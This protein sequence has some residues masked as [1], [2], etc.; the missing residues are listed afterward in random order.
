MER[1]E[2]PPIFYRS[3]QASVSV[4]GY[5]LFMIICPIPENPET[6]YIARA[7]IT[8]TF[9]PMQKRLWEN[10]FSQPECIV[11]P[12]GTFEAAPSTDNP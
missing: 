10:T 4:P 5:T 1:A 3:P 7:T 2:P 8:K 12:K 11:H 9:C 6:L